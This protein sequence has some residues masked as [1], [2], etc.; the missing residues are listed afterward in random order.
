MAI[1]GREEPIS[2]DVRI[3]ANLTK[4]VVGVTGGVGILMIFMS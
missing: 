3:S 1:M 4:G 2:D